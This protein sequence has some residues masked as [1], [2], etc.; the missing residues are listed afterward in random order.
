MTPQISTLFSSAVPASSAVNSV[1]KADTSGSSFG[2]MLVDAMANGAPSLKPILST[3]L[4][5]TSIPSPANNQKVD[6]NDSLNNLSIATL[7]SDISNLQSQF[8]T[9]LSDVSSIN[10]I[11]ELTTKEISAVSVPSAVNNKNELTTKETPAVTAQGAVNNKNELTT[12]E[13]SAFAASNVVQNKKDLSSNQSLQ[14]DLNQVNIDTTSPIVNNTTNKNGVDSTINDSSTEQ[15]ELSKTQSDSIKARNSSKEVNQNNIDAQ[16]LFALLTGQ[17]SVQGQ[18]SNVTKSNKDSLTQEDILDK[19]NKHNLNSFSRS[20]DLLNSGKNTASEDK[21]I[22]KANL[23]SPQDATKIQDLL[24]SGKNP[25]ISKYLLQI[26]SRIDGSKTNSDE[27]NLKD[28]S[29]AISPTT[30]TAARIELASKEFTF[31]N[32]DGNASSPESQNKNLEISLGNSPVGFND[33]LSK[34]SAE[35]SVKEAGASTNQ[36]LPT[37]FNSPNWGP[38]L[39]QRVTWMI[40]DQLQNATITINPPHLGQIEVR[41]QTDIAQQTSV[42]FMSNNPE[43]RQAISENLSTLRQMMSQ[44]GLQ[45]GQADVGSRD[46][47]STNQNNSNS[48]KKASRSIFTAPI[49]SSTESSQGIGLI[50]TFA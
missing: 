19:P 3:V 50:N 1:D 23:V 2:N 48:G 42:H 21:D 39:N 47:S 12:K 25:E 8:G 34:N 36:T 45:L 32:K 31:S 46:S 29:I 41:L 20:Q 13:I 10:A 30:N 17:Q 26:Q 33:H 15:N 9:S 4:N 40:K 38:A 6:A 43:V 14:T 5:Q 22:G 28:S 24:N 37:P 16:I 35:F 44:S 11:N 49:A 18:T 27:I 7:N